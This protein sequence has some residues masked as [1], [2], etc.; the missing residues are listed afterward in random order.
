MRDVDRVAA[1]L[2]RSLNLYGGAVLPGR[3]DTL[4]RPMWLAGRMTTLHSTAFEWL[5]KH[6]MHPSV[7]QLRER[8]R[9]AGRRRQ[10]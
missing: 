2:E 7:R 5:A 8:R 4:E 6:P 10:Y 3:D 9:S 1:A